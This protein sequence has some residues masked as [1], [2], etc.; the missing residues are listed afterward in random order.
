MKAPKYLDLQNKLKLLATRR[1]SQTW[2][3]AKAPWRFDTIDSRLGSED[4]QFE[5]AESWMQLQC[6]PTKALQEGEVSHERICSSSCQ[7]ARPK[8][9]GNICHGERNLPTQGRGRDNRQQTLSLWMRRGVIS[10]M[11]EGHS[12]FSQPAQVDDC[13][14][15]RDAVSWCFLAAAHASLSKLHA[16]LQVLRRRRQAQRSPWAGCRPWLWW[17]FAGTASQA[18]EGRRG[19]DKK[20]R[21]LTINNR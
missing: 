17:E 18:A 9:L 10:G 6:V 13:F 3:R 15:H 12:P 14:L 20:T 21:E 19:L 8:F 4:K 16:A 1:L 11:I 2:A 5:L 7:P